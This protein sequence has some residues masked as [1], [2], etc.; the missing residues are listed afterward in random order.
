MP[1]SPDFLKKI[2]QDRQE[3]QGQNSDIPNTLPD[4]LI[5][6]RDFKVHNKTKTAPLRSPQSTSTPVKTEVEAPIDVSSLNTKGMGE[7]SDQEVAALIRSQNKDNPLGKLSFFR[8][9]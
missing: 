9:R 8:R 6:A 7:L 3:A 2:R 1:I 5:K 4:A